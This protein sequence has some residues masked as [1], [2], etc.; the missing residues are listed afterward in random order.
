MVLPV[1]GG[2]IDEDLGDGRSKEHLF[3][4]LSE[5]S[6]VDVHVELKFNVLRSFDLLQQLNHCLVVSQLQ[7]Q[8]KHQPADVKVNRNE[9][10]R[11]ST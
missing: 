5:L 7:N 10:E 4:I 8:P 2:D 1:V 6:T 9:L 3:V 11:C